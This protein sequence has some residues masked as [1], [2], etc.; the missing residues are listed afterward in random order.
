ME[1]NHGSTLKEWAEEDQPREKLLAKG[2]KEVSNAELLAILL[3][4]GVPGYS[5]LD[6]AKDIL[7]D[8]DNQLID[9]SR[10]SVEDL[11]GMHYKGLG[12]TKAITLV[13]ALE[14]GYRMLNDLASRQTKPI[15]RDSDNLYRYIAPSLIDLHD[16]EFWVVYLTTQNQVLGKERLSQGGLTETT[17]DQRSIFR[18]ALARNATALFFCHNHPSGNLTPSRNDIDL[19]KTLV[20]CGKILRIKVLDHIIV[21]LADGEKPGFFSFADNGLL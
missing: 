5:A 15:I 3:R 13:A 7:H 18:N 2:K 9:L 17:V 4:S 6:M 12:P 20:Q 8:V 10:K 14:L 21:G 1:K 19:T 11:L 16:E